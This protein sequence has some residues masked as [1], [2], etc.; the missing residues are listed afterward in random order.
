MND[1]IKKIKNG[2]DIS[3]IIQYVI[4]DIYENGPIDGTSME[5]LCYL[6]IYQPQEFEKWKNRILKYM[7]VYYKEN[8]NRILSRNCFWYV[9]KTYRRNL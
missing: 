2:D 8:K 3:K 1:L 4:H 9:R 6:S 7:G 5:I